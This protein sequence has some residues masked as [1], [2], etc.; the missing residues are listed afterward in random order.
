MD[1]DPIIGW[2]ALAAVSGIHAAT[3]QMRQ[4]R[5]KLPLT[6]HWVEGRRAFDLAEVRQ[7]LD[8]ETK[9]AKEH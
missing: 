3:L 7:W 2:Q 6:R 8:N 4:T 1:Q 5:G 9:Q